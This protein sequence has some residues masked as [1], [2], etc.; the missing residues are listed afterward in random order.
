MYRAVS[1]PGWLLIACLMASPAHALTLDLEAVQ[2]TWIDAAM[3]N[4]NAGDDT[5]LQVQSDAGMAQRA[6][7][8]FD[9]SSIKPCWNVTSATLRMKLAT[10]A[11]P[12]TVVHAVHRLGADWTED[13]A[14]WNCA[15]D[16]D[17]GNMTQDCTGA[18]AWT[19]AGGDFD[20]TPSATATPA[21][22]SSGTTTWDVTDDVEAFRQAPASNH[23]WMIKGADEGTD[24]ELVYRSIE[25][26]APVL[27]IVY[28][29][30]DMECDDSEDCTIDTCENSMSADMNGCVFTPKPDDTVC[31]DGLFC[32][33]T[34]KCLMGTCTVHQST[35][36]CADVSGPCRTTMCDEM[37]RCNANEGATCTDPTGCT[38]GATC[39]D[40]ECIGTLA[41]PCHTAPKSLLV[42]KDPENTDRDRI[43]WKWLQ[44]QAT[45]FTQLGDPTSSTTYRLCVFSGVSAGMSGESAQAVV[46]RLDIPPNVTWWS[47]IGDPPKG[48]KY[49]N[50]GMSPPD[51]V[52]KVLMKG[53]DQDG[54]SKMLLKAKGASVLD[55][56]PLLSAMLPVKAQLLR[57]E[58]ATPNTPSECWESEFI[59][60]NKFVT[61]PH[62]LKILKR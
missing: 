61:K 36:V 23:G 13:G 35:N 3:P 19:A 42:I 45:P 57:F 51:G 20:P 1:R 31:D 48:Y 62:L 29:L 9:V 26:A 41:A 50:T 59:N 18:S 49:L 53:D 2:D 25:T 60:G 15:E 12:N 24:F 34:D 32:N 21:A 44:G 5:V 46:A 37:T 39:T 47:D 8:K 14:T 52:Y 55:N 17:P 56:T 7:V 22:G 58:M 28:T 30:D 43:I 6:L 4:V 40:G 10:A 11:N 33:G 38:V 27:R 16:T 54:A